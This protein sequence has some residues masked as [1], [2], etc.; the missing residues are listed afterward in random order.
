M[1][2]FVIGKLCYLLPMF[3]NASGEIRTKLH[4]I[5]MTSARGAIG[6]YCCRKNTNQILGTCGWMVIDKLIL[7][8]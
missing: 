6:N 1:N 3:M 7:R 4:N 8:D 2:G 5:V